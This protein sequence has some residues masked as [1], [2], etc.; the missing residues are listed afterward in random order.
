MHFTLIKASSSGVQYSSNYH[1][2]A[3]L[4]VG[5]IISLLNQDFIHYFRAHDYFNKTINKFLI[6][7][8]K[9]VRTPTADRFCVSSA[10]ESAR[11][12]F[13]RSVIPAGGADKGRKSRTSWWSLAVVFRRETVDIADRGLGLA[14]S[15]CNCLEC[16]RPIAIV[17]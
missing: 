15:I 16:L 12:C 14:V 3:N 17:N 2:L 8:R 11:S 9:N 5:M 1:M 4:Q 7:H 6:S 10:N 13:W